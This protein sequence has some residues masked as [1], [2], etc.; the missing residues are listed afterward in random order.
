MNWQIKKIDKLEADQL[1]QDL[2]EK[3]SDITHILHTQKY[4]HLFVARNEY[5]VVGIG[6]GW[7]NEFHPTAMYFR[8]FISERAQDADRMADAIFH[9]IKLETVHQDKWIWA[10]SESDETMSTFLIR[11]GFRLIRKT[12]MPTLQM[13]DIQKHFK[14]VEKADNYISLKELL[15]NPE[16]KQSF[17]TL[18]KETYTATHQVNPVNNYSLEEWEDILL[19]DAPD[20][21]HSLISH[22]H[23]CIDGFIMMHP[24]D[25]R[26]YEVGWLGISESTEPTLLRRLLKKQ[27]ESLSEKGVATLAL[28]VDTTDWHAV[29]LFS[30]IDV[31]TGEAWQTYMLQ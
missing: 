20:Q 27:L 3:M 11:N 22:D 13:N 31:E 30:F 18:L 8:I 10:G 4:E 17:F 1:E 19:N 25:S 29:K 23:H 24:V 7:L 26:H 2:L 12:Y 15:N 28:E 5:H 6:V 14:N 21:E 9:Q 16:M